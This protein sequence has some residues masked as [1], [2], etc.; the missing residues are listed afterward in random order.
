MSNTQDKYR[1]MVPFLL[2][3]SYATP[4]FYIL[5]RTHIT[6][7][8]LHLYADMSFQKNNLAKSEGRLI[9]SI[10]LPTLWLNE[11]KEIIEL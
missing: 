2:K 10:P 3:T 11:R 4:D 8:L 6:Y 5:F 9:R 7:D 1:P